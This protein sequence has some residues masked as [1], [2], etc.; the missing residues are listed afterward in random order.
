MGGLGRAVGPS[1]TAL[2]TAWPAGQQR[3]QAYQRLVAQTG[4]KACHAPFN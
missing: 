4:T 1:S 3:N 2:R